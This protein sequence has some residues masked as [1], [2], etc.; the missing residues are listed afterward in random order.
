MTP[1]GSRFGSP[2]GILAHELLS[3]A[4]EK[5]QG[6]HDRSKDPDTGFGTEEER[7]NDVEK[8][9]VESAKPQKKDK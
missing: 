3:H 6:T 5:D 4:F 9:Y 1:V 7:A 2:T 8:I